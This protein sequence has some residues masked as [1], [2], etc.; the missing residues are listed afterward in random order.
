M[1]ERDVATAATSVL[2][3]AAGAWAVRVH[4]VRGTRDALDVWEA[5]VA[6]RSHG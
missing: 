4:D 1:T 3:A 2:A 5:T 6:A